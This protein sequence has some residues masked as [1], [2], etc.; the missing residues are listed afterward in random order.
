[1]F[2]KITLCLLAG[3]GL[4]PFAS[5]Q[6]TPCLYDF[7]VD[8]RESQYPGYRQHSQQTIKAALLQYQQQRGNDDEVLTIPVIVHVVWKETDEN[9]SQARI[10]AQIRVLN[11]AYRRQ[12]ADTVNT[13]DI[14]KPVAGDAGIEFM[15]AQVIRVQTDATFSP[16]FSLFEGIALPEEVKSSSDGGSDA[17]DTERFLNIWVCAIQPLSL[18]GTESPILGYA[19]PPAGLAHW[20]EGVE[21]PAP[22]Q[23]GVVVD[24][25]TFGDLL[26]Y[27]VPGIGTLPML[28]RTSVHEVGHYLGLRHI[29][30][31]GTGAL[32]GIPDCDADDGVDDTPNQGLQSQFNCDHDQNTCDEGT[33]DLPDMIENYMDYSSEDCQNVFTKGQIAIMRAVLRGPRA[34]LVAMPSSAQAVPT[35]GQG[36]LYPNPS[37]GEFVFE[38]PKGHLS[39]TFSVHD[40]YGQQILPA[41]PGQPQLRIALNGQPAGLYYLRLHWA[42]GTVTAQKMVLNP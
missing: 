42:D 23:E 32:L 37:S 14:F 5:A 40:A 1:M 31:D 36:R 2:W 13:R 16:V 7:A 9:I 11:E 10:D 21:A 35:A 28:G 29:S 18:F 4:A 6:Y 33:D 26:S 41:A 27:E 24:Y 20:P 3:L 25:R 38:L 15:L 22:E 8:A 12:N 17:I 39:Y 19:Y 30:G 34:E